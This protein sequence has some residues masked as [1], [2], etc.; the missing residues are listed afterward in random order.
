[1]GILGD[2]FEEAPEDN[3]K[4]NSKYPE[5]QRKNRDLI[6]HVADWIVPGHGYMFEN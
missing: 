3:W 2:I 4:M 6:L 5:Q 1:M